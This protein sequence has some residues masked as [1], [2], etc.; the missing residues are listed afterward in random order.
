MPLASHQKASTRGDVYARGLWHLA[1]SNP[2]DN[3]VARG[4]FERSIELDPNFSQAYQGLVYAYLDKIRLFDATS[5]PEM[6]SKVETL[7]RRA[8]ALDPQDAKAHAGLGW[9]LQTLADLEGAL[10]RAKR[11]LALNANCA[12]AYR[13]KG[14]TQVYS[15][16]HFDGCQTLMTHLRLNPRDDRNWH[17]FHVMGMASY[18]LGDHTAAVETEK[19]AMRENPNQR[20]SFRWLAAALAQLGRVAEA[21]SVMRNLEFTSPPEWIE[22]YWGH[23]WPWMREEDHANLIE[24]LRKAGWPG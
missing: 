13:L 15:G 8:V 19:H 24:G 12:E 17:A 5:S 2:A 16:N 10:D 14:V 1:R 23:R 21:Q 20:L 7:A 3:D 22:H 18:L 9:V 11:A 6:L 4:L